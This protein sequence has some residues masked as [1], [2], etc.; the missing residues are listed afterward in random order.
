VGG[1]STPPP[2]P[3]PTPTPT[4]DPGGAPCT[5]CEHFTGPLSGSGDYDWHPNGNYYYSSSG[6]GEAWLRGPAGTDFDLYLYKWSSWW[7]W[8][9][10]ASSISSSSNE[11]INYNGTSGYYVWRVES[12]SGSGSY[13]LWLNR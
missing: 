3:T 9:R 7:G 8:Y 6:D 5:G 4:P 2:G 11:Y 1:G 12:Y 10:V 13:D